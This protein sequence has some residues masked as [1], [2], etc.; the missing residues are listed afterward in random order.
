M[1]SVSDASLV[2]VQGSHMKR[3]SKR[4]S[5]GKPFELDHR[6][7]GTVSE[8]LIKRSSA[9]VHPTRLDHNSRT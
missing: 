3:E 9:I 5:M 6:V 7:G 2:F 8:D 4:L 1:R